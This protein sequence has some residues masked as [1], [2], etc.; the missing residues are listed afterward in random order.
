M[1]NK[2]QKFERVVDFDPLSPIPPHHRHQAS[3]GRSHFLQHAVGLTAEEPVKA[4]RLLHSVVDG[5]VTERQQ[6]ANDKN[7]ASTLVQAL[8]D[9]R[10]A[11]VTRVGITLSATLSSAWPTTLHLI[12][13]F[14]TFGVAGKVSIPGWSSVCREWRIRCGSRQSPRGDT[15]P[16]CCS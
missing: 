13:R 12:D 11:R 5:Y 8:L 6:P 4:R 2:L 1:G 15:W 16:A 14:T 3:L 7:L 10:T 9:Y